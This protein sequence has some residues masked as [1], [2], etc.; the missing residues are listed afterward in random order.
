MSNQ[1]NSLSNYQ[2]KKCLNILNKL[3][4]YH[5]SFMFLTPVDPERDQCPEY[6]Q[7][8][9]HPMDLQTVRKNLESNKYA[10]VSQFKDDVN[11]IWDNAY[12]FNG[13]KSIISLLARQL[14][15]AFREMSEFLTNNEICDWAT[16]LENLKNEVNTIAKN[17]PTTST[18]QFSSSPGVSSQS[19][20]RISSRQA[21]QSLNFESASQVEPSYNVKKS[22][23]K[24]SH[25]TNSQQQQA[26]AHPKLS[27]KSPKFSNHSILGV[28]SQS[29]SSI[30]SSHSMV[31]LPLSRDDNEIDTSLENNKKA[32]PL[33]EIEIQKLIE[34]IRSIT[35]VTIMHK[36]IS[37]IKNKNPSIIP[38]ENDFDEIEIEVS[39]IK[40]S[41][42]IEIQKFVESLYVDENDI[43]DEIIDAEC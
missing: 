2:K 25:I 39:G 24:K 36:I 42:L 32:P 41:T 21:E 7:I 14:Q 38:I 4:S 19:S 3:T 27:K 9:K 12:R 23:P 37:M 20:T 28:D 18:V 1:Q 6:F 35:D 34:D 16:E 10:T 5:I 40:N 11:L 22:P 31:N 29:N 15:T 13:K 33:S 26:P 17:C 30:K 8:I 43:A